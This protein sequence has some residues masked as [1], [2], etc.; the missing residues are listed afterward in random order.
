MTINRWRGDAPAVAQQVQI[1]PP[2][3]HAN[4]DFVIGGRALGWNAAYNTEEMIR[5]WSE[6]SIAEFQEIL[7][8]HTNAL[9]GTAG[10]GE[11][12]LQA[13]TPGKPFAVTVTLNGQ[14]GT[15]DEVQLISIGNSPTG[16]TFTLTFDGQ[17]TA[18]IAHNAD[19]KVIQTALEALSN[20]SEGDVVVTG[21]ASRF[22]VRYTGNL[23]GTN[24]P[25]I[26]IDVSGLTGGNN[27]ISVVTVTPGVDGVNEKQRIALGDPTGGTFTLTFDGQEASNIA[28]NAS[29]ATVETALEALS[30]V[31][32]GN[33]S[34][35]GG[36]LPGTDIIVEFIGTLAGADQPLL[37][38][39]GANLSG[40]SGPT[41]TQITAGSA[42]TNTVYT[43]NLPE[44]PAA[45]EQISLYFLLPLSQHVLQTELFNYDE[46]AANIEALFDAWWN[47]DDE[48]DSSNF[49]VSGSLDGSWLD[50]GDGSYNEL[51]IT[52]TG[53][54]QSWSGG[55]QTVGGRRYTAAASSPDQDFPP[56][57]VTPAL[58][59][60]TSFGSGGTNAVA[61]IPAHSSSFKI[62][63][64][65]G[66]W[67]DVIEPTDDIQDVRTKLIEAFNSDYDE[68]GELVPIWSFGPNYSRFPVSRGVPCA[69]TTTGST[70]DDIS[71]SAMRLTFDALGYQGTA[72]PTIETTSTVEDVTV[73]V[74]QEPV[75]AVGEEKTISI[76][77]DTPWGGT[78]TLTDDS[79]NTTGNIAYD[80][81]IADVQSELQSIFGAGLVIV[82]GDAFPTGTM[83]ANFDPSLG[84]VEE[85][86]GDGSGLKNATG[87]TATSLHGGQSLYPQTLQRSRGPEHFDDPLNWSQGRVPTRADEI[88][89]EDGSVGPKYGLV[90][91]AE[92]TVP[93]V[94]QS[95]WDLHATHDLIDGQVVRLTTTGSLPT[96]LA[97]GTDYTIAL[98]DKDRGTFALRDS[99]GAIV[100]VASDD[101]SGTYTV[102]LEVARILAYATFTGPIGLPRIDTAG[103]YRQYRATKLAIGFTDTDIVTTIGQGEGNGS[104]LMRFDFGAY[105]INLESILTG[106][107][108]EQDRQALQVVG[109]NAA[110]SFDLYDGELGIAVFSDESGT[111]KTFNQ[112]GGSCV[113]G[114]SITFPSGAVIDKTAGDLTIMNAA[115]ASTVFKLRG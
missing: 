94:R 31:G 103:N 54:G 19:Q 79:D 108:L 100:I 55:F 90:Q 71:T 21:S 17:T 52:L 27:T 65:S 113:M 51:T 98:A 34:V 47:G 85:I 40:G 75:V 11:L 101:G 13:R 9:N 74:D 99:S 6:S 106:S 36:A 63:F 77:G 46:T 14:T 24:Q 73:T 33:V 56:Y 26:T 25:L 89:Y 5:K 18:G 82:T 20:I 2:P 76:V 16:G 29:A 60:S 30:N 48:F 58:T 110:N 61:E 57:E 23:A 10:F 4:I 80:A 67:S 50:P 43:L 96:G 69:V 92:F 111:V 12:V 15:T 35:T 112:R 95:N 3:Y 37:V 104:G 84:N 64:D 88:I 83:T 109:S 7:A 87:S 62:R 97:T 70:G 66:A 72:L 44:E 8:T 53:R 68:D 22:S 39:D 93:A 114:E 115:A 86:T 78:L 59:V 45:G 41:V 42:G 91:L 105:Q 49:S 1:S 38:G 107:S 32:S 28:Y 81:D 102:A